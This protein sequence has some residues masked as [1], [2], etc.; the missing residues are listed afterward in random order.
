MS[1]LPFG[2]KKCRLYLLVGDGGSVSSLLVLRIVYIIRAFD[3]PPEQQLIIQ[4]CCKSYLSEYA[5]Y[6]NQNYAKLTQP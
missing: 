4:G 1:Y 6:I 5:K 2:R 3:P